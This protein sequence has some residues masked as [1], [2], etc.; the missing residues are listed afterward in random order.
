M[1]AEAISSICC[2]KAKKYN[3]FKVRVRV[4]KGV[5]VQWLHAWIPFRWGLGGHGFDP[6]C[7]RIF[8][9]GTRRLGT[10]EVGK[11]IL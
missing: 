5:I 3:S 2:C 1:I 9:E 11:K 4:C 10:C 7:T 6:C 8:S